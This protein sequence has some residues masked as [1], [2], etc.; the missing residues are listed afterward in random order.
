MGER[1]TTRVNLALAKLACRHALT[2]D[3][4]IRSL[5]VSAI[6]GTVLNLIN[7]GDAILSGSN[8]DY[9]KL[10]LTYV[11]PYFVGT[12]GA[13]SVRLHDRKLAQKA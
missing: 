3:V 9:V 6:V 11:V 4:A 7:Q 8:V 2:P 1:K 12:Y 13:V 10:V 5:Y